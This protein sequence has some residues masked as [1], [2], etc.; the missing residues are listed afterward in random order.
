M[1]FSE[2]NISIFK[3]FLFDCF[4]YCNDAS[5]FSINVSLFLFRLYVFFF[6]FPIAFLSSQCH[7]LFP[8]VF[9]SIAVLRPYAVFSLFVVFCVFGKIEKICVKSQ[10][11]ATRTRMREFMGS[12]IMLLFGGAH[13]QLNEDICCYVYHTQISHYTKI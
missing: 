10:T 8:F 9:Q 5:I 2:N 6:V 12:T 1:T 7:S 11:H 3:R 4:V 13:H